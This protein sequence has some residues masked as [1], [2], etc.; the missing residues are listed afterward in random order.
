MGKYLRC[1]EYTGGQRSFEATIVKKAGLWLYKNLFV[2][3]MCKLVLPHIL[4]CKRVIIKPL[5]AVLIIILQVL[6]ENG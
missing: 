2:N 3:F 1:K 4:L 5:W 6:N